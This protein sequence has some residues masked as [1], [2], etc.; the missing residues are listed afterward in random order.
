MGASGGILV[1]WKS[2]IFEGTLIEVQRFGIII[3]FKSAQSQQKWTLV[4][5]YGPC[6]GEQRDLFN[7]TI[8]G[9]AKDGCD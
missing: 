8:F 5:V 9:V 1:V 6:E 7:S 4:V 2:S 3:S